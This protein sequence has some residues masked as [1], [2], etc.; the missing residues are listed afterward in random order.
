MTT[1]NRWT[2]KP[3]TT[4]ISPLMRGELEKIAQKPAPW[5]TGRAS[6]QWT[7]LLERGLIEC[8]APHES[9]WTRRLYRVTDAGRAVLDQTALTQP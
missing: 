5:A 7:H 8:A 6:K 2:G 4:T 9:A 1:I 3:F